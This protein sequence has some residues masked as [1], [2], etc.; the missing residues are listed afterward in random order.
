MQRKTPLRSKQ[1]FKK[2]G[3]KLKP[4]SD[5]RKVLNKEYAKVRK[6]YFEKVQGRCEVCGG[7]ATDIHH[8]SKR[9][10]NL[11]VSSTFMAVCRPCH[12]R[13]ETERAWAKEMGYLIYEYK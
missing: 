13:I 7:Q 6:E 10:K 11:C 1:G 8:K 5:R 9:G 12:T 2:H 4:V 3:G